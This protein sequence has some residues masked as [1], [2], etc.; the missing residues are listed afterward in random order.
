MVGIKI[1]ASSIFLQLETGLFTNILEQSYI[2]YGFL[3]TQMSMKQ[4]WE[5]SEPF[6]LT[7]RPNKTSVWSPQPQ[8]VSDFSLMEYAIG[9]Y[10]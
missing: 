7:L 2:T 9:K 5:E 6:G 1:D 4:I 3:A 10:N 8:G